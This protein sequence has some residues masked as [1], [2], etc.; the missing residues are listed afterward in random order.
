MIEQELKDLENE[1]SEKT[2]LEDEKSEDTTSE[3]TKDDAVNPLLMHSSNLYESSEDK[4]KDNLSSAITF[5]VC[6]AVGIILLVLNFIGIIKIVSKDNSSFILVNVVLGILFIGFI[7]IGFWS[8]KYSKKIKASVAQEDNEA[9]KILEW[10]RNNITEADIENSYDNDIA[11]EMKYFNR[12]EYVKNAITEE[13]DEI[14]DRLA[15]SITDTYLE[16]I[17]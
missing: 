7:F 12:S 4:Y 2:I 1:K 3:N 13:F 14:D 16:E 10:L 17:F 9:K 5:F 6:G 15:D 8:L 11:E